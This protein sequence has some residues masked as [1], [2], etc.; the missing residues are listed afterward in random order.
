MALMWLLLFL[1]VRSRSVDL[2]LVLQGQWRGTTAVQDLQPSPVH[3]DDCQVHRLMDRRADLL[4]QWETE[5]CLD[6]AFAFG[7]PLLTD[8]LGDPLN[9]LLR[10]CQAGQLREGLTA[11]AE[12]WVLDPRKDD[13]LV[14]GRTVIAAV[15]TQCLGLREKSARH[16]GQ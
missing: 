6:L 5:K 11:L 9:L 10:N 12:G 2:C 14:H 15:N 13:H 1:I 3:L 16:L 7:H 4:H 8:P